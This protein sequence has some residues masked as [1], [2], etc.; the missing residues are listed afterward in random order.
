MTSR[1]FAPRADLGMSQLEPLSYHSGKRICCFLIQ[2]RWNGSNEVV[3][4]EEGNHVPSL[5]HND[6]VK[7]VVL[8][9]EAR[10]P[11][12]EDHGV[13]CAEAVAMD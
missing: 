9:A 12:P 2:A 7:R 5:R 11:N 1:G 8:V 3:C 10:Q 4:A 13:G 6:V